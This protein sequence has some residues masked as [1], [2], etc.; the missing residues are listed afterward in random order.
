MNETISLCML[1]KNE[2]KMLERC[3]EKVTGN[4]EEIIIV[5]N[6]ST[7]HTKQ[8]AESYGAKVINFP[9]ANYDEGRNA[10]LSIAKESW[11]LVLDADEMITKKDLQNIKQSLMNNDENILGYYLPN[12][13]Y[14]GE[15]KWSI[16]ENLRLIKNNSKIR[17]DNKSIH[18]SPRSSI[19]LLEGKFSKIVGSSIHH[20]DILYK[21]RAAFK[22]ERNIAH[23]LREIEKDNKDVHNFYYLGIEYSA[24]GKDILAEKSYLR[25]LSL[26]IDN[27][28][29]IS[30]VKL[31]LAQHYFKLNRY[32]EAKQLCYEICDLNGAI[33]KD[34]VYKLLADISL[35]Y[36][37]DQESSTKY[38]YKAIIEEPNSAHYLLNLAFLIQ[39]KEPNESIDYIKK[40]INMNPLILNPVIYLPGETPNIFKNQNS[41]LMSF[42]TVFDIMENAFNNLGDTLSAK[43][44]KEHKT[45]IV[46]II[47]NKDIDDLW[48]SKINCI[49][50]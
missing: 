22:R 47:Q 49:D 26:I 36:D 11:I 14:I 21:G 16:I 3:L 46:D 25:S 33:M 1:V 15:G 37:K 44:W 6:G 9:H 41:F 31:Y 50:I 13:Q 18:S 8:I 5:D 48:E 27:P 32:D 19:N 38:I 29:F 4:V 24:L 35:V 12:F 42:D 7:D 40:A 34:R 45:T 2:A 39:D 43:K 20:F 10:Y 30:R 17:Y 23:L 28:R